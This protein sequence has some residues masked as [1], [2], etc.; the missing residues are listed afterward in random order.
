MKKSIFVFI[1]AFVSIAASA[2]PSDDWPTEIVKIDNVWYKLDLARHFATVVSPPAGEI[3]SGDIVIPN[4]FDYDGREYES[5]RIED[6]AFC[7]CSD[8]M[9]VT[10]NVSIPAHAFSYSSVTSVIIGDAVK[11]VGEY[12][13]Y[14]C[15]RLTNVVVGN[16]V[17][18]IG[19][20][21]FHHCKSLSSI[22]LGSSVS[23]LGVSAF[24]DCENLKEVYC[25][26]EQ[27]PWQYS[28]GPAFDFHYYSNM[29]LYVPEAYSNN[30]S[31]NPWRNFEEIVKMESDKM[32]QCATPTVSYVN[33]VVSFSCETAGVEYNSTIWVPESNYV[34]SSDG[35]IPSPSYFKVAVFATKSGLLRSETAIQEYAIDNFVS[36]VTPGVY[37]KQ[38][39]VNQDGKVD[40]GDHVK[41]SNIILNEG[42]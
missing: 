38:G 17:T 22:V 42:K 5:V 40:V 19:Q 8:I 32:E 14:E 6:R 20:S 29:T 24:F 28:W 25:L 1:L 31:W 3:Y 10:V 35:S 36:V 27:S 21:A 26:G 23:T 15:G 12:A 18:S 39:D 4:S 30:Y 34:T 9:S 41:L 33:G 2:D 7:G 13:F 16:G 37:Y 11:S